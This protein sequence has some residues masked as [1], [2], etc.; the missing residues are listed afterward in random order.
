MDSFAGDGVTLAKGTLPK[1]GN[2][3]ILDIASVASFGQ[4]L[5]TCLWYDLQS[6]LHI[7]AVALLHFQVSIPGT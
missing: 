2:S 7:L 6:E 5:W 1:K 3:R 4:A